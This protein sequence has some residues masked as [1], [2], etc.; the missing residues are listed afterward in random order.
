[1]TFQRER[2]RNYDWRPEACVSNNPNA[3]TWKEFGRARA[4]AHAHTHT[5]CIY[6]DD[7]IKQFT[8]TKYRITIWKSCSCHDKYLFR[9][10][11]D[12]SQIITIQWL[13]RWSIRQYT[14]QLFGFGLWLHFRICSWQKIQL[15]RAWLRFSFREIAGVSV[16]ANNKKKSNSWI[17]RVEWSQFQAFRALW[18]L[19]ANRTVLNANLLWVLSL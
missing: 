5:K 16:F 11:L 14:F 17:C 19:Q 10:I 7:E 1:M 9:K 3:E 15:M 4:L 18:D 12:N 13:G 2:R 6:L 8:K